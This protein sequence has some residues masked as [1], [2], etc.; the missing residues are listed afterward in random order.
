LFL[1]LRGR[2]RPYFSTTTLVS[3]SVTPAST[4]RRSANRLAR[5]EET[6]SK[7]W[8]MKMMRRRI[9]AVQ[10]LGFSLVIQGDLTYNLPLV[11]LCKLKVQL[12]HGPLIFRQK[13][14]EKKDLVNS[15]KRSCTKE[16][17]ES[18]IDCKHPPYSLEG[19]SHRER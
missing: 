19:Y 13:E 8:G 6:L 12:N 10:E 18:L 7:I 16:I 17:F 4:I 9:P 2:P 15:T 11:G 3:R 14:R 1:L 5:L